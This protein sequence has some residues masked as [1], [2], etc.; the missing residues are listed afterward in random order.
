MSVG[1]VPVCVL[2]LVED[3]TAAMAGR[4]VSL[5]FFF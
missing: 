1:C 5:F 2:L 4:D 3:S